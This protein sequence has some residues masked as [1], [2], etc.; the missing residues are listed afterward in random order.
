MLTRHCSIQATENFGNKLLAERH[1]AAE[2]VVL[3]PPDCLAHP[4]QIASRL[5][6]LKE[7]G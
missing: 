2:K 6:A 1:F 5:Q 7:V 3:L 4:R